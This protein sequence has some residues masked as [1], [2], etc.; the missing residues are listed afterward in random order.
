MITII[1]NILSYFTL[2]ST[3]IDAPLA[4]GSVIEIRTTWVWLFLG[5][6]KNKWILKMLDNAI[7]VRY[8]KNGKLTKE[9]RLEAKKYL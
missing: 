4:G 5:L 7:I 3:S 8:Y 6:C 2:S 9:Y 1:K